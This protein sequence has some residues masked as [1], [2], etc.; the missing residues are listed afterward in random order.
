LAQA[1][2]QSA[3]RP[4]AL[5]EEALLDLV[6]LGTVADMAPLMDENRALVAAG[7]DAL[8]TAPRLGIR[9]LM[10][11]A[12][13]TPH[14]LTAHTL[15]YVLAPRL[16]AAGRLESAYAAYRLLVTADEAQAAALA[17]QLEE[18]NRTRQERTGQM[19]EKAR[20]IIRAEQAD[21]WLYL[22]ADPDFS[23]GIAG[24]V[25][26]R[27]AEEFYRP[28]LVAHLGE[29][30]TRGSARS[31][32]GLHITRALD[33]CAALLE[34]Y[35]GHSS[36]AG[37]TVRNANLPTLYA[38]L[39][40]IAVREFGA[41]PPEPTLY[42]DAELNLRAINRRATEDVLTARLAGHRPPVSDQAARGLQ[43]LES[44][45]CLQPFGCGNSEPVFLTGGMVVRR[46][47]RVGNENA[48]L[49]LVLHDGK[50]EWEAIAFRQ[51]SWHDAIGERVD[52]AYRFS[53]ND[54]NGRRTLQLV[55]E[56]IRAA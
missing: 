14:T 25:A 36:A 26:A 32:P 8:R 49:K 6:A 52:V 11:R 12:G 40:E 39:L 56:D 2:L 21:N 33:E 17:D 24:L 47:W 35:G 31:I 10:E 42:I 16:N 51:A 18:Q 41:C 43:V 28:T 46:K 38:R 34:R 55:L 1:L 37:F 45:E 5:R 13:V 50:Q 48:H 3:E 15:G 29:E 22:V 44:V 30:V 20:Q 23:E 7:I 4:P 27:L 54:Y 9:K 19:L 53:C